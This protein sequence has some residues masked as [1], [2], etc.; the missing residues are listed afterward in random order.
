MPED[1][2]SAARTEAARQGVV[3]LFTVA[4][5]IVSYIGYMK[6]GKDFQQAQRNASDPDYERGQRMRQAKMTERMFAK[7]A[8]WAYRQAEK[9]RVAYERDRA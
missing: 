5:I 8:W 4:G 6:L 2:A 9:A 1:A 7:L 3:L